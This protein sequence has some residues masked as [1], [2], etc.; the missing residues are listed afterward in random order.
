MNDEKK[1]QEVLKKHHGCIG[2]C[3]LYR[4]VMTVLIGSQNYDLATPE[5][6]Y[7]TC[8]FVLP[9][10]KAMA[11]LA[12]PISTLSGSDEYGHINVKDIRLAL[13]NLKK[14]SPNSVECFA[15]HYK[16]AEEGFQ[17]L[18]DFPPIMFRCDTKNMMDSIGG[19]AEQLKTRNMS[20]GKRLAHIL[21]MHCMIGNYLDIKA[22]I[23]KMNQLEHDLA[24]KAKLDPDNPDWDILSAEWERTI[25][26]E[27][28]TVDIHC[29]DDRVAYGLELIEGIQESCV[30]EAVNHRA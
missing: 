4:P 16:Y 27:I 3:D 26:E 8:T 24:M 1:I 13:N 22:D 11:T 25:Q 9:T 17:F 18:T 23:L 15:S 12:K 2:A 28:E 7:D 20:H 5:S 14:T 10:T 19:M 21:R 29:Y 6:D 30:K